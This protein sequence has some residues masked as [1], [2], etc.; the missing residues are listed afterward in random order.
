MSLMQYVIDALSLG[1][2]YALVALGVALI[3]GVMRL[4]NFASGDYITW[5]AYA[6]VVPSA[7]QVATPFIGTWPAPLLIL[8]VIALIV[9]L[10]LA[11]EWLAF[12]PLRN[13]EPA[14]LLISSFAVSYA[15]QNLILLVH[16]G[17]PKSINL[18]PELMAPARFAGGQAPIIDL[19]TIA[20]CFSALAVVALFLKRTRFGAEMRAASENFRMAQLLGI[21]ADRVIGTAFAIGGAL[22]ALTALLLVVKTGTLDYRMGVPITLMG[23]MATVI[24]GMGGLLGPVLAGFL[25]GIATTA[26][27]AFLPDHLRE[28]RDAFVFGFALILLVIAP[29]GLIRAKSHIERV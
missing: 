11:T 16:G 7:A 24:G 27:Q 5:A 28:A 1:G 14:T 10:A 25:I 15:L 18:W 3:F 13:A 9:L 2:L 20:T 4:I 8:A 12:R 29:G 17:R 23:F 22:T 19:V 6:L 26:L 21:R